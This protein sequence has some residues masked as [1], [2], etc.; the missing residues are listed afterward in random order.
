M[1]RNNEQHL[2]NQ[3]GKSNIE[4]RREEE[5][6]KKNTKKVKENQCQR[7]NVQSNYIK[8]NESIT[9][10]YEYIAFILQYTSCCII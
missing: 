4:Q 10:H 5:E 9:S 3:Y 1:K 6:T 7:K 2:Q 8:K